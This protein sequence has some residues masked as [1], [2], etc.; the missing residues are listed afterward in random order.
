MPRLYFNILKTWSFIP[1]KTYDLTISN[2][3]KH[4]NTQNFLQLLVGIIEGDGCIYVKGKRL[5]L[6]V[7]GHYNMLQWLNSRLIKLG[8]K[9]RTIIHGKSPYS[10]RIQINKR[11]T[12]KLHELL[13]KC[14]YLLLRR[15]WDK[16]ITMAKTG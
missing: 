2:K 7:D 9:K 12:L 4:I 11:E 15:K 14:T 3:L 1:R 10:H 5:M 13:K 8:F 6:L 16:I